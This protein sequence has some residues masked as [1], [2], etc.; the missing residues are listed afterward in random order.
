[1]I[2]GGVLSG[3][4]DRCSDEADHVIYDASGVT[5]GAGLKACVCHHSDQFGHSNIPVSKVVELDAADFLDA[6]WNW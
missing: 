5:D 1:M 3:I 2:A 4:R 6:F